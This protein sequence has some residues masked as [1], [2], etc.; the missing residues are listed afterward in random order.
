MFNILLRRA[1]KAARLS[2]R[3]LGKRIGVS[4]ATIKKYEDGIIM[5]SS[6]ILIKLSRELK[7]RTHYFFRTVCPTLQDIAYRKHYSLPKKQLDAITYD[8]INQIERRLEL[9]N[10]FPQPP[11]KTFHFDLERISIN[12]MSEIETV[13]ERVRALWELGF[14]PIL[15]LVDKLEDNGVRVFMSDVDS[16]HKFHGLAVKVEDMPVIVVGRGWPGDRQRFTIAHELGHLVLE[17]RLCNVL[18]LED[19]CNRF[20]GAFLFPAISVKQKLGE[21]RNAIELKELEILKE[22]FGLSMFAILDRA[23]DLDI[24]TPNC[25]KKQ[26]QLFKDKGWRQKEPGVDYPSEK[27]HIFEQLIFHALGEEYIGESKAAE[28]MEMSLQQFRLA[29]AVG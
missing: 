12:T 28:L 13:A 16:D 9:E 23:L 14:D 7:V 25:H 3:E 19:A 6:D 24:I 15:N 21:R 18:N 11:I 17:N 22:E 5:P 26:A 2:L 4:H 8:I 20:A 27:T 29:R 10:L 1:R